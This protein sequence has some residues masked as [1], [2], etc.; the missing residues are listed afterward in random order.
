MARARMVAAESAVASAV[1]ILGVAEGPVE[2]RAD[3]AQRPMAVE[4]VLL[5]AAAAAAR[6]ASDSQARAVVVQ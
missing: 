5:V 6:L 1:T 3:L 4:V 2:L